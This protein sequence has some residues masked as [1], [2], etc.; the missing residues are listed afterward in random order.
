MRDANAPRLVGVAHLQISVGP[1]LLPSSVVSA[2]DL[3]TVPWKRMP[4][5]SMRNVN[6]PRLVGVAHLQ[7]PVSLT[8]ALSLAILI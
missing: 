1:T 7:I 2:S 4:A 6:A 3:R 8:Q 5:N